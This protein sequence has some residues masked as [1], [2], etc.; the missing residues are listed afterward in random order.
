MIM[1]K[2]FEMSMM[3]DLKFFLGFQIKQLKDDTFLSQTK[4]TK[5]ILKKFG[6][7][8]VKPIMMP[9]GPMDTLTLT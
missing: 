6:M 1:I 2:K 5:Y 8:D 4:Y 7:K 9:M 3:G